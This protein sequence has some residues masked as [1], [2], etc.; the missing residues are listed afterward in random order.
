MAI[1]EISLSKKMEKKIKTES[2]SWVADEQKSRFERSKISKIAIPDLVKKDGKKFNEDL[3]N[4][5]EHISRL[6]KITG[7]SYGKYLEISIIDKLQS[8]GFIWFVDKTFVQKFEYAAALTKRN[9]N[10]GAV[11]ENEDSFNIINVQ[12]VGD[13]PNWVLDRVE[14]AM[15]CGMDTITIHSHY[16][17]PVKFEKVT[18][19][20]VAI[21]WKGNPNII[22]NNKGIYNMNNSQGVVIAIW[23]GDNEIDII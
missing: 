6:S 11:R 12:Y 14:S 18:V 20:P 5:I 15:E 22:K 2:E 8:N 3:Y 16:P 7:L 23:Q 13:I 17:L 10:K 1:R 4:E 21:A 19:D 9:G